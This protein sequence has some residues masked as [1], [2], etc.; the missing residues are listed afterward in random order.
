MDSNL[1]GFLTSEVA[2]DRPQEQQR[3]SGTVSGSVVGQDGVALAGARVKLTMEGRTVSQEVVTNEDG[4]FT[5]TNVASGSFQLTISSEG[6][7]A[8]TFTGVLHSGENLAV[9]QISMVLATNVTKVRVELSPIEIAQEQMNDEMKQRVLGVI[10]NFYV[11]YV[12]DAAPLTPK[13][14]TIWPRD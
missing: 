4:Q 11:T 7:S 3:V 14:N 5:F 8:H 13:R 2:I 10:P 6:F 1:P 12:P 9:P